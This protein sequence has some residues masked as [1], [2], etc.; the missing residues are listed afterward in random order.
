MSKTN[1]IKVKKGTHPT[2]CIFGLDFDGKAVHMP[3]A[4]GPHFL[5]AGQTGSG[6]SVFMNSMLISMIVHNSPDTLKISWIDPK[7]VEA[8][9]YKDLPYSFTNP[10][11]EMRDAYALVTAATTMMDDRYE[12][13]SRIEVKN[14]DEFNEWIDKNPEKA[15]SMN[16]EKMFYWIIVIDEFADLMMQ[17]SEV[18]NE[19]V[20][21]GQKA[22]ACGI[23]MIIATQRPSMEVFPSLIKAN[24]PSR[25]GLK[26]ADSVN[27]QIIIDS[28][29][30][31]KLKGCG[32]CLLKDSSGDITRLQGPYI[33][34][35]EINNI[36]SHLRDKYGVNDP[37]DYKTFLVDR[38]LF[39][40]DI[41]EE[42]YPNWKDD[43][44]SVPYEERFVKKPR[45]S[46]R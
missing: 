31:E 12:D 29:G 37:F 33:T 1:D 7:K 4:K 41:N 18:S 2:E 17:F 30:C 38:N 16:L 10:V 21:L 39:E 36:F 14:I 43:W 42:K 24:I 13:L 32:D 6:K 35:D 5:C 22:R 46:R 25:I 19:V 3:L 26:T 11:T 23:H 20:R 34:N 45:R 15:K 8:K 9:A 44:E 40:W 28:D 27:S